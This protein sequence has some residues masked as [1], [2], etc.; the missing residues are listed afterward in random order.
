MWHSNA[1]PFPRFTKTYMKRTCILINFDIIPKML[2]FGIFLSKITRWP[3]VCYFIMNCDVTYSSIQIQFG[4]SCLFNLI[5]LVF[6]ENCKKVHCVSSKHYISFAFIKL[7]SFDFMNCLKQSVL[8]VN[9]NYL[10]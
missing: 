4:I 1:Y 10:P 8:R 5:L 9:L 2:V 7:F 3:V 6:L